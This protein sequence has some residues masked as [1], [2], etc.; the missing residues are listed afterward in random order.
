MKRMPVLISVLLHAAAGIAVANARGRP[1]GAPE[2]VRVAVLEKAPP[3][4]PPPAEPVEQ[5]RPA[6]VARARSVRPPRPAPPVAAPPPPAVEAT[7]PAEQPVP[8]AGI[9][10][11]S[12]SAAGSFAVATGN[13]L[14]AAPEP[15]A[16]E[17]VA[18]K[19]YKAERYAAAAELNEMPEVLNRDAVDIRRYY[20]RDALRAAIEG[21]VILRLIIDAD[22]SI[23]QAVVVRDPGHGMGSAALRAV[24]E[25]RFSPG[26]T[27]GAPVAT[28]IPFVIRF[29]I[30]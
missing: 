6:P 18:V 21:D 8:V 30:S 14:S 20:P 17:P 26:K 2:R 11:G 3:A 28:S 16:R 19:P 15:A 5:P 23:A 24:R 9:G 29:V 25:F 7:S 4:P 1:A 13:T 22:G 12:T 27:G 10:L